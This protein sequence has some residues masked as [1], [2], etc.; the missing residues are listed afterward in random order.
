LYTSY[1]IN[2]FL[3]NNHKI[4]PCR[5]N[6]KLQEVLKQMKKWSFEKLFNVE[7]L[8]K[9]A[10][11]FLSGIDR[12][13]NIEAVRDIL[14]QK[15]MWVYRNINS[16]MPAHNLIRVRDCALALMSVLLERSDAKTG[17]SV[18]QAL[19]DISRCQ[20]RSDLKAGFYAEMIN[21][22]RGMEGRAK[23][24][25]L[26]HPSPQKSGLSGREQ[27]KVRS[28]DL[29]RLW[30]I[31][32][33]RLGTYASGLSEES[34]IKREKRRRH[35]LGTLGGVE[36]DWN[37]WSWHVRNI[38]TNTKILSKLTTV[39]ETQGTI[40]DR[41]VK[42]R[43]PFGITPYYAS[44]MDEK[45]SRNDHAI[46]AQV[47]PPADYVDRMLTHRLNR[48]QS[49]DYMLE[50]DT[51]PIELIT[52]R[53]PGIVILKPVS[54]C[55]Q[56]CV[57]CQRNWEID[58]VMAPCSFA[59]KADIDSAIEWL[60]SHPAVREVLV[61]GGDPFIMSDT[62]LGSLLKR[63]S[64]IAHIDMIRIGTRTLVTL[65]M[66]IT[67]SFAEMLGS[68]REVGRRDLAVITHVEH[69]YEITPE[70]A[71]AVDRLRRKGIGVYNQQVYTFF[72]SR[73][74]ESTALRIL[75][76][77]IGIDPY[78]TFMPKGKEETNAYRVP[79]ARILQEQKEEAR[80]VP[81]LRR[82]DEA[83]FNIPGLGK[84]Y[85]RAIQHRNLLTVLPDG[86]RIYEFHPWEM[87]LVSCQTY[88]HKDVAIL[89][90]MRRLS[91]TGEDPRDYDSI[92]YYM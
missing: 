15:V 51:S 88:L 50:S 73:R 75:L 37:D 47:L 31:V 60:K 18:T 69:P 19:W 77:R 70:T 4:S 66:R 57:Y 20:P 46:R 5:R 3:I 85:L 30:N 12:C 86:Q 16:D 38:I 83:V 91:E 76:R 17:F 26:V 28:D 80:L 82:T 39:D 42:G 29:D 13:H 10:N 32:E 8:R 92:W 48:E 43:L 49:F 27:A 6:N 59:N 55:P 54:T 33:K 24:Q 87:N 56:I 14:L 84:N 72:V 1:L 79:I 9:E 53:Y 52:R 74:F 41:A 65:P 2:Y 68:F 21:W 61:T 7:V 35:V 81:G 44:L 45:P 58:Q 63:L 62:K 25:F 34:R 64:E 11:E 71:T 22:I 23:F 67:E 78:Y 36:T 90:Y 89:D 40:I